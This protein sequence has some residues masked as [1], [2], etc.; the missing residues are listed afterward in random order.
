MVVEPISDAPRED[1]Q[2][3][4]EARRAHDPA[5]DWTPAGRLALKRKV[6]A[7][8]PRWYSPLLHFLFPSA[9]GIAVMVGCCLLL[10]SPSA[11]SWL[12]IPATFLFSNL[13][14]WQAHKHALHKRHPLMPILYERHTPMHHRLF[15]E[16]AMAISDW[17]ELSMV[18]LPSF[19]VFAI[20]SLQLPLLGLG[21]MF[22]LRNVA[23]LFM[24]TSMGY[25]LF[26]EW[27]HLSYHLP[28]DSFIG[29]R[30]I[31]RRLRYHHAH[32]HNPQLMQRWNMNVTLPLCDWVFGTIHRGEPMRASA[33]DKSPAASARPASRKLIP[34]R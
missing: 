18:L 31:I 15:T 10:R 25:V 8:L 29:R 13:I 22:G 11:V 20:L 28:D 26:Y 1:L 30:S 4:G 23:L 7:E 14:E 34:N 24:A 6:L 21:L 27:L 9:V 2:G 33:R 12:T 19:G 17:R 3:E 16:D 5:K 32:H